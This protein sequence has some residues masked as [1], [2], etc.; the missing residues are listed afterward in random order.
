MNRGNEGDD[1]VAQRECPVIGEGVSP[2][3]HTFF[4]LLVKHW[5]K[6]MDIFALIRRFEVK[7]VFV[8]WV[9]IGSGNAINQ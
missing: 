9:F 3:I 1:D 5:I 4:Y 2:H 6:S 8:G 7:E